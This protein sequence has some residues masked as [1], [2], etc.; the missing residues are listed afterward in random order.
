MS[1]KQ[2]FHNENARKNYSFLNKQDLSTH[3]L[4]LGFSSSFRMNFDLL[5]EEENRDYS[6]DKNERE[7]LEKHV[8]F[9]EISDRNAEIQSSF[10]NKKKHFAENLMGSHE[11]SRKSSV[12]SIFL[13]FFE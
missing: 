2:S 10:L 1:K 4:N 6:N 11:I 9:Y 3:V 8:N 13:M 7:T 5:K 12:K